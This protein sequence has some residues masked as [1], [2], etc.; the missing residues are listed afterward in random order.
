MAKFKVGDRV[1]FVEKYGRANNGDEAT[2]TG[3]WAEDGVR[4]NVDGD[5]GSHSCLMSRVELVPA[6]QPKVGDRVVWLEPFKA[7]MYTK[8]KEYLIHKEEYG[9][10]LITDDTDNLHHSWNR[11]NIP[12]SFSL[13]AP[14]TIEAGKFYKTRD[15]R[16][17]GP[18]GGDVHFAYDTN[19][20]CLSARVEDKTRLFRQSSGI[21]LFGDENIDLIA[22]WVDEPVAVA[23]SNDNR[24]DAG[25][26]FK[27]GDRLRLIDSPLQNMP[28][29]TEVIA[30]ARTG[31]VPSSVHFEQDGRTTWR[32]GSYFELV[33]TPAPTAIVALIEDGQPKPPVLP[34]VHATEAAAAKE[35]ARLAS[36]HKGQQFGVYVLTT[37]SQEAAPTYAHEWQ[38]LAVAGRKIDAIKELRSVTG[39]QLKPAKDVVEHF[40]DNPY[41]Q[42]A[43]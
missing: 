13:V 5:K 10:L 18:M 37:T 40:V 12:A 29:G 9:T 22:E 19:E 3:F 23:A 24:A 1:R 2:I 35:A 26:G 33:T 28:L 30:V 21:H 14:L 8:G 43:A 38:R 20:P 17:V 34:H 31:G 39:M 41:G 6:W 4:V 15:G 7:S 42:L 36:V 27:V 25:G 11:E 16:K 32:P